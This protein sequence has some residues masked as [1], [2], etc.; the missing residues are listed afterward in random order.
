[1]RRYLAQARTALA[2]W[3]TGSVVPNF[4]EDR[5]N[6]GRFMNEERAAFVDLVRLP[7]VGDGLQDH[8]S[9]AFAFEPARDVPPSPFE[10]DAALFHRSEPSWIGADLETLFFAAPPEG[11]I[12]MRAGVIRP[13]SG[14]TVR[15]RSADPQD[16]PQLDPRFLSAGSDL[17]RPVAGIR[18]SLAIAATPPLDQWITGIQADT[19]PSGRHGRR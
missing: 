18:E 14:G 10:D 12:A 8:V 3:D 1:M 2:Q 5:D 4:V 16:P 6:P 11:G 13:M 9:V 7:G 17:R 19:G 15:L